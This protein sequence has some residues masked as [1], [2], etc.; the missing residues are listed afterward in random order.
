M[1]LKRLQYNYF[2]FIYFGVPVVSKEKQISIGPPGT[3]F[4][5]EIIKSVLII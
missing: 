3:D 4:L 2:I 1:K 5:S